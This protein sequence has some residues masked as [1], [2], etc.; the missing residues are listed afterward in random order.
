L[1]A[2]TGVHASHIAR[3]ENAEVRPSIEV[4]MKIGVA[5]GADLSIRYFVG[6]GPRLHD[7]F[8]APMV[9]ALLRILDP[10]WVATPEVPILQPARG[11]VDVVLDDLASPTTIATESQSEFRRLEQQ[12]RWMA[13]KTDG[14]AARLATDGR[15][16][17][18]V[19]RMLLL[20]STEA[21]RE[22]ARRFEATL[23]AAFPARSLDAFEALTT[24]TARW[25]GPGILWVR[26]D[27]GVATVLSTPPRGVSLG[28]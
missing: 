8:Q 4:L 15:G 25:P 11:V 27:H 23:A 22:T 28:R 10:R 9:E 26:L 20:R 5:L 21:T 1:A 13:E 19:S 12:V 3:V 2:V 18:V 14:L 24:P 17:R 7:R 6:V 16:D